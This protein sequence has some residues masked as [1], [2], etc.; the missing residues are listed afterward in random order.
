MNDI[1]TGRVY[2]MN[3]LFKAFA[4]FFLAVGVLILMGFSRALT[5]QED[6]DAVKVFLAILLPAVGI[7]MTAKAFSSRISFTENSVDLISVLGRKSMPLDQIRGRREYVARGGNPG[8][9]TRYLRLE[10][11]D[12]QP[13]LDFGKKLYR[14]DDQFWKW[15]NQL[16]DLDALDRES[17][18]KASNF[19]LV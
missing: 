8:A 4:V 2:R 12:G 17:A 7:G 3:W 10:T 14:F 19:G 13:P 15:F 18:Q 6:L 9:S 1:P 5:Q 16:P 11:K